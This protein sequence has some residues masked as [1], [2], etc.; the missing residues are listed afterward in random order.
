MTQVQSRSVLAQI[1]SAGSFAEQASGLRALRDEIIGHV[2]RKE[3]WIR[4]GVL[5]LLVGIL[6]TSGQTASSPFG[7]KERSQAGQWAGPLPDHEAVRLLSLQLLASF[8]HGEH[9][10]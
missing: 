4:Q 1:Q 6:Q 2:Q 7:G 9:C 8:E 3:R 10:Q 5:E